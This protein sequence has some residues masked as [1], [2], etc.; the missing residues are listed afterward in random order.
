MTGA[1]GRKAPRR[2]PGGPAAP[3]PPVAAPDRPEL[4]LPM[5]LPWAR[6]RIEAA[7]KLGPV[8]DYGSSEWH[9]LAD[10]DPRRMAAALIYA[11]VQR[12]EER[13]AVERLR[14]ELAEARYLA[15]VQAYEEQAARDAELDALVR[16]NIDGT[17][18]RMMT[19]RTEPVA[20]PVTTSP[21][22]PVTFPAPTPG[23]E[24]VPAPGPAPLDMLRAL[25]RRSA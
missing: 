16:R 6:E 15:E 5:P 7:R 24:L 3:R 4:I 23:A 25:A 20:R 17:V 2:R 21:D 22:W 14:A 1:R 10:E 9:A 18:R 11:E 13:T 12:Y 19:K 8:P